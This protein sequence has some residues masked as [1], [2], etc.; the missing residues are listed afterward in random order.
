[1]EKKR[2]SFFFK[3]KLY[4]RVCY[5]TKHIFYKM[6]P[7]H[8]YGHILPYN[9]PNIR[10]CKLYRVL[11]LISA[12][13]KIIF[14]ALE[15]VTGLWM[16]AQVPKK[17]GQTIDV[18]I[19]CPS[20]DPTSDFV[21]YISRVIKLIS[22]HFKTVLQRSFEDLCSSKIFSWGS[23]FVFVFGPFQIVEESSKLRRF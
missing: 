4:I 18:A 6:W 14:W 23:I 19:F 2:K 16:S 1:M 7:N 8:K 10:F 5:C 15:H 21:R 11:K 12:H 20:M 17:C 9:G 3:K 22:A 13:F